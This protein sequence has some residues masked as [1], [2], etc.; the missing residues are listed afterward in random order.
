MLL[1]NLLVF[2]KNIIRIK[3]NYFK[4]F[5]LI[6]YAHSTLVKYLYLLDNEQWGNKNVNVIK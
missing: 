1:L 2:G 4:P 3:N 6:L 5:K